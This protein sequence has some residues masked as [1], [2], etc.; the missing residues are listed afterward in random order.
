MGE[1]KSRVVSLRLKDRQAVRLDRL[2][3]IHHRSIGETAALMLEEKLKEQ[4]FAFIE[5]RDSP[6]GRQACVKGTSLAVWEVVL[7]GRNLGMDAHKIAKHLDWPVGKV[8][9]ALV[10][11]AANTE[12]IDPVVDEVASMTLEQIQVI[13]PWVR[14]TRS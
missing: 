1:K 12:E 6:E 14:G 9:S 8:Q 5:F 13:L 4:E 11:A 10:Y 3:R 2:A 7:V